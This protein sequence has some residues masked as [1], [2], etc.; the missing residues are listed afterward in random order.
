MPVMVYPK[1]LS[2]LNFIFLG[3]VQGGLPEPSAP[4]MPSGMLA[5][6]GPPPSG[7]VRYPQIFQPSAQ[8]GEAASEAASN[9]G[10]WNDKVGEP[11]KEEARNQGFWGAALGGGSARDSAA[12]N[13][14]RDSPADEAA[15]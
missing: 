5:H 11:D 1:V 3:R 4:P 6:P 7:P 2:T 15:R 8:P 14:A 9:R 12:A 10:F 13:A